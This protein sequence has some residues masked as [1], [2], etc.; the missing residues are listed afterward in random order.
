MLTIA[1]EGVNDNPAMIRSWYLRRQAQVVS[2]I[3]SDIGFLIRN[4]RL[5]TVPPLARVAF[6]ASAKMQAAVKLDDYVAQQYLSEQKEVIK[7][8]RKLVEGG[9][10]AYQADLDSQCEILARLRS[11]LGGVREREWK[12]SETVEA[13]GLKEESDAQYPMLSQAIHSTVRGLTAFRSEVLAAWCVPHVLRSMIRAT[14]HLLF[15]KDGDATESRPLSA[16]WRQV[17]DKMAGLVHEWKSH[18]TSIDSLLKQ[19][20]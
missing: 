5:F 1:I 6:E 3:G 14:E 13:A 19:D 2:G 16:N 10:T 20:A 15:F 18:E 11:H 17:V 9:A 8:L 7:E 12:F 4:R